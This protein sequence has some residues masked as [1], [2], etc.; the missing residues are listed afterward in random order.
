MN[1][2]KR[3]VLTIIMLCSIGMLATQANAQDRLDKVKCAFLLNFSKYVIWPQ[4]DGDFVIGVVGQDPF[5]GVLDKIVEGKTVGDRP[6]KTA[7][8]DADA[9]DDELK[10]CSILF[11]NTEIETILEKIGN[12]PILTVGDSEKFARKKGMVGLI[13]TNKINLEINKHQADAAGL[14]IHDK[15]L[16][17][18]KIV[19]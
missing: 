11:V 15:L 6:I 4:A 8:L 17:L 16:Q 1:D 5:G 9:S 10:K 7:Y 19:D 12:A 18:A 3:T 2:L 13:A 14:K